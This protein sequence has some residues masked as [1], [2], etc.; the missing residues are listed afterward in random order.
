MQAQSDGNRRSGKAGK[1]SAVPSR[2]TRKDQLMD[3]EV[4]K[5]PEGHQLQLGNV[6][7]VVKED[8]SWIPLSQKQ[9]G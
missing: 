3:A 5:A 4:L 6:R 1:R 9:E 8:G 7:M 2:K